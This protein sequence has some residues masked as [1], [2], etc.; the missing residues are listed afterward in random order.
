VIDGWEA[1][2]TS[3][4]LTSQA[5]GVADQIRQGREMAA[6]RLDLRTDRGV[7]R[8]GFIDDTPPGMIAGVFAMAPGELQVFEAPGGAV[9][10]RLDTVTTPDPDGA[11]AR[12]LTASF[13]L[14]ADQ[15]AS[16]DVLEYLTRAIEAR[17]GIQLNQSA[18]SAVHAQFP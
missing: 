2:E 14:Q 11:E 1:A 4:Q 12:F 8:D 10:V 15:A 16:N 6:L 5:L 3:A 9:L 17:A 13:A 7:T 18:L